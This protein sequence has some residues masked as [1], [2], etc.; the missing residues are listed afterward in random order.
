MVALLIH[1]PEFSGHLMK[2][3]FSRF[4]LTTLLIVMTASVCVVYYVN[5]RLNPSVSTLFRT[6][7]SIHPEAVDTLLQ[8]ATDAQI[9]R[10]EAA[11]ST[12][13]P[14]A[15]LPPDL[16]RLYNTCSGQKRTDADSD[17]FPQFRLRPIDD[18]ISEYDAICDL[19]DEFAAPH[20]TEP[21]PNKWYDYRLFPFAWS[22]GTGDVYCVDI[23]S[24]NI[25]WF[26]PDGGIGSKKYDSVR[27]LLQESIQFQRDE[28]DR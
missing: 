10:A 26:N 21:F 17:L 28:P 22:P 1:F 7:S 20:E 23:Q 24:E 3:R 5:E 6:L 16:I 12:H 19:Y 18:A 15:K 8:P 13:I 2:R 9:A 25:F 4:S 27:D 14:D 11:M